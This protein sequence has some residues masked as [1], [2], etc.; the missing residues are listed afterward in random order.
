VPPE[1][2]K[3]AGALLRGLAPI[4]R[5]IRSTFRAHSARFHH[6]VGRVFITGG[7]SS[8]KGLEAL[9]ARELNAEV[10]RLDAVPRTNSPIDPARTPMASQAFALAI[11]GHG[12]ARGAKFN[13][14]KGELA[15]KGDLDY[16]KGKT[17]R[18]AV[19]AG[20]LLV[21]ALGLVAAR[22]R[23]LDGSEKGLDDILCK[24]TQRVVGKCEKNYDVALSLL[25]GKGSPAASL[26]V[27][28]AVDLFA[29]VTT[30]SQALAVVYDDLS[31]TLERVQLHGETESFDAVDQLVTALKG[32]KCFQE[33]KRGK[34]QKNKDGSKVLFDLDVRVQCETAKTEG[35]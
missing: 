17:S 5:E 26:P 23:V 34:V 2:E 27:Y 28:S 13:L 31:I 6:N 22:L 12:S 19:F 30:R 14:R 21:L 9:L 18:L 33:I 8:L 29:E 11:R 20:V 25:K 3:A 10:L 15:F 16:L 7:T 1:S 35:A 4:I 24:T 32:F